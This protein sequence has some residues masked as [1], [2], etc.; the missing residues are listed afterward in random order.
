MS[1]LAS[2]TSISA[3][4]TITKNGLSAQFYVTRA[5]LTP[6]IYLYSGG[7]G[8]MVRNKTPRIDDLPAELREDIEK[9][10]RKYQAKFLLKGNT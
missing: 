5:G 3:H 10:I 1:V 2:V 9:A 8:Y 4:V 6:P 7:I